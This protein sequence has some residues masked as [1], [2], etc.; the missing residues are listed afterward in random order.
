MEKFFYLIV[1]CLVVYFYVFKLMLPGVSGMFAGAM[2]GQEV[3]GEMGI[4]SEPLPVAVIGEGSGFEDRSRQEEN[5]QEHQ[6]EG[7]QSVPIQAEP[8]PTL[9]PESTPEP[10]PEPTQEP[11]P[12]FRPLYGLQDIKCQD[13]SIYQVKVRLTNYWPDRPPTKDEI[14]RGIEVKKFGNEDLITTQNC[15]KYSISEWSCVSAMETELPWR[16]FIGWAA[17]CPYDWPDGTVIEVPA[18]GRSFWCLDRGTMVCAGGVCDV[19]ILAESLPQN[20]IV[21][22]AFIKVSGW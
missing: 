4:K 19:D 5:V 7:F 3:S 9:T 15:W 16:A 2:F 1:F 11:L 17:A 14:D 13:C 6:T 8:T 18:L 20:G 10:M 12:D 22:D 21:L